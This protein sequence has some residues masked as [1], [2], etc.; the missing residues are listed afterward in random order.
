[1][2]TPLINIEADVEALN[3]I[4]IIPKLLEVICRSTGMGFSA[5]ARV[6]DQKWITCCVRDEI[7]F[8][9]VP[10]SE[11]KLETT[12]CHEIR[13]SGNGVIIDH[14]AEDEHFRAH[15]TPAMYGFESYISIPIIKQDGS[16]FGTLCAIDPRPAKLNNTETIGMF[17][18]FA[19][20]ISFHLNAIEQLRLSES[21]LEEE[22]AT[23]EL[24][25]QFI[26][27]LGHDLRNPVGAV[28]N[29]A[30]MLLRM[31][32]DERTNRLAH[33]IQDS[34]YRMKALIENILDFARGRMGEGL[35]L[36]RKENEPL[37]DILTHVIAE[38]K[39]IWPGRVIQSDFSLNQP[40]NCDGN[41]IAQLFSNLLGNALT[42]GKKDEPIKV[43]AATEGNEFILSVT[44]SGTKIPAAAM[45]RLFH[46]FFRGDVKPGQQGLGLGLYISSEIAKAHGGTLGVESSSDET[47]FTLRMPVNATI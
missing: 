6:T 31:P 11:L 5:I 28:A 36:N 27:I 22:R 19:D 26:A 44:N 35:N 34:S 25:E 10:G 23:A 46:P 12:I 8:G 13:Q 18:L 30:Q 1:L 37:G 47:C 40:V 17:T 20:L 32:L 16:F 39:A 4:P 29:V 24:R 7:D 41:R 14:V 15:H 43:K 2:L 45:E 9:L 38:L 21:K 42:H 33:I 3:R